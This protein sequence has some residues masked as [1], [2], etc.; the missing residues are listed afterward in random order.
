MFSLQEE[1]GQESPKRYHL[2]VARLK[3]GSCNKVILFFLGLLK[4]EP[5][6]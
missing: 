6:T 5:D 3:P 4:N 2:G 1:N